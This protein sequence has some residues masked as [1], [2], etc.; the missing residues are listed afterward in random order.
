MCP[1]LLDDGDVQA[2]LYQLDMMTP[3]GKGLGKHGSDILVIKRKG[4]P[5]SS[6]FKN[7]DT[8]RG[9]GSWP[10]GGISSEPKLPQ[11]GY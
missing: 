7:G 6:P 2:M 1:S 9:E 8:V 3:D 5:V 10:S 11:P 4:G